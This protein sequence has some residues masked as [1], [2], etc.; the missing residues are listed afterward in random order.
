MALKSETPFPGQLIVH[1]GDHKAGSTTIQSSLARGD[2]TLVNGTLVY[3]VIGDRF[4][5]NHLRVDAAPV[6]LLKRLRKG[7]G[8]S[9]RD[10]A[11]DFAALARKARRSAP[12][13]TVLSAEEL[14]TAP[15]AALREALT[16]AF[17]V[18]PGALWVI[19]YFRPHAARA[20]SGLA[21]HIKIGWIGADPWA[22]YSTKMAAKLHYAPRIDAWRKVFGEAYVA[23]PMLRGEL[24][25]G[26]LLEDLFAHTIGPEKVRLREGDSANES[27]G[28]EDL[29]R[30][31]VL[32]TALPELSKWQHHALGWTFAQHLASAGGG[33]STR[34]RIHKAMAETLRAALMDDARAVDTRLCGDRPLFAEELDRA[35][36]TALP[37]PMSLRPE[38][39][40]S[41][42]EIRSLRAIAR[43][44][45]DSTGAKGW[46]AALKHALVRRMR[47]A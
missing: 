32:H 46:R 20:I 23:R 25:G 11:D 17:A 47:G 30:L 31:S 6:R 43:L 26:N 18:A 5:H 4:N 8:K 34:F 24:T 36:D 19:A 42:D 21:E 13:V 28:I 9:A 27:L 33:T 35:V 12:D 40:L 1:V 38:D 16:R 10:K 3:P 44:V 37:E 15:P 41:A 7:Q 2:V 45:E 22:E 29:M 14:E 39:W